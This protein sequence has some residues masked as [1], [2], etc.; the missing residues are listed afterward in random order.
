TLTRWDLSGLS[1][2][3]TQLDDSNLS[4]VTFEGSDLTGASFSGRVNLVDAD[5]TDAIINDTFLRAT[6][7]KGLTE[8]QVASTASY[9]ARSLVDIDFSFNDFTGWDLSGQDFTGGRLDDTTFINADLSDA[10][11]PNMLFGI[12]RFENT[13]ATGADFRGGAFAGV[14]SFDNVELTGANLTDAVFLATSVPAELISF[15]DLRGS[16]GLSVVG[17]AR[18][19]IPSTGRVP[20]IDVRAGETLRLWDREADGDSRGDPVPVIDIVVTDRFEVQAD[21]TLR[22]VLEDDEWGS[23]I[24]FDNGGGPPVDAFIDG[25]LELAFGRGITPLDLIAFDGVSFRLFDWSNADLDGI[26]ASISYDG[27]GLFETDA[28]LTTGFV[29]YRIPAPASFSVL[30][31][32]SACTLRRR[33]RDHA[34][35]V[36]PGPLAGHT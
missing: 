33:S 9:K 8:G 31:V 6:T 13:T 35:G 24:R 21:A 19:T 2:R 28:L 22:V 34:A 5:L 32:V 26:F 12:A 15:A 30:V 17:E 1:L 14:R 16:S 25:Q 11:A 36:T 10:V 4:E 23:L 29:T 7:F 18:N 3:D 20:V 27:V